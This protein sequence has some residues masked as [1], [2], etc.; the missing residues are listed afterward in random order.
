MC[1][2]SVCVRAWDVWFSSRYVAFS[3]IGMVKCV[4]GLIVEGLIS[5]LSLFY[6][7]LVFSR[8]RL[9][10]SFSGSPVQAMIAVPIVRLLLGRRF[11]PI[12]PLYS[13]IPYIST[14][15]T[16]VAQYFKPVQERLSCF[17]TARLNDISMFLKGIVHKKIKLLVV[18]NLFCPYS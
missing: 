16:L 7:A 3:F 11:F 6:E 2:V 5:V 17:N 12:S 4:T 8:H 9:D 18:L 1:S 14:E 15:S 10:W 13:G